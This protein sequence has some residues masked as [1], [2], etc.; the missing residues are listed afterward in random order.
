[1]CKQENIMTDFA[2]PTLGHRGA[3]IG[4][5]KMIQKLDLTLSGQQLASKITKCF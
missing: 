4:K 5:A 3:V 2:V 1:M